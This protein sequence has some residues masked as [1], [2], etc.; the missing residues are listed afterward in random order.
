MEPKCISVRLYTSRGCCHVGSLFCLAMPTHHRPDCTSPS[1]HIPN[2]QTKKDH[3]CC[4]EEFDAYFEALQNIQ[5]HL[6]NRE[7]LISDTCDDTKTIFV[8]LF[9]NYCNGHTSVG[10]I[11]YIVYVVC[12]G[13]IFIWWP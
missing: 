9:L 12:N 1:R 10:G 5:R 6:R 11:F 8:G 3:S 2:L 4:K 7:G 13:T